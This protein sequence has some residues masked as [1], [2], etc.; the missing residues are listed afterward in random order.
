ML[1]HLPD[2]SLSSLLQHGPSSKNEFFKL[3]LRWAFRAHHSGQQKMYVPL[4]VSA[5]G[6]HFS[7]EFKS[8]AILVT[9]RIAKIGKLFHRHANHLR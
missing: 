5:Q 3:Y 6:L 7:E 9:E 2:E 8:V 4:Q 1:R